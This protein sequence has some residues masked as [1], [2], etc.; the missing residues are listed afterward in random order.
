MISRRISQANRHI[1][2]AGLQLF[3]LAY[4]GLGAMRRKTLLWKMIPH[5]ENKLVLFK[6]R[7]TMIADNFEE[8]A[9]QLELLKKRE[10]EALNEQD[11]QNANEPAT[12]SPAYKEV[13]DDMMGY[14]WY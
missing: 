3:Q 9:K 14:C 13:D 4:L 1:H 7:Y 5:Y 8:I 11:Q 6:W 10:R 2:R 12:D